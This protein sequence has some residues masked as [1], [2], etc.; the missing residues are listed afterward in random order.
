MPKE[1]GPTSGGRVTAVPVQEK[2]LLTLGLVGGVGAGGAT[3]GGDVSGVSGGATVSV[4]IV[5][6]G[7]N[8]DSFP[9][10]S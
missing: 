3:G 7:E 1:S 5:S 10:A 4:V 8:P 6:D 2:V 9:A